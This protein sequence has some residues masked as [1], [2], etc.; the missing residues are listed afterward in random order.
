M[1][2]PNVRVFTL[3]ELKKA[4]RNFRP[5]SFVGEGGFGRV[6]KGF[7]DEEGPSHGQGRIP[8]AIKKLDPESVQG[9]KEWKVFN[10]LISYKDFTGV[11]L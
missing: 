2:T 1:P 6:F 3:G 11:L 4:T 10:P 9:F 7:L 5:D 8:I